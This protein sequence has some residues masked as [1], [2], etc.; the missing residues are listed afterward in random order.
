M[1]LQIIS[2]YKFFVRRIDG[3]TKTAKLQVETRPTITAIAL[4]VLVVSKA[5]FSTQIDCKTGRW[6]GWAKGFQQAPRGV[7][8]RLSRLT[9]FLR[10]GS[11]P[12]QGRQMCTAS[13]ECQLKD[14]QP[15][16]LRQCQDLSPALTMVARRLFENS[17]T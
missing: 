12:P 5:A 13:K 4:S 9:I 17:N 11:F 10:P 7:Y 16:R 1:V 14:G 15:A 8:P 2:W 3:L 6:T